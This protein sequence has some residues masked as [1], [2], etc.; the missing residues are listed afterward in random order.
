[1]AQFHVLRY[2]MRDHAITRTG[3]QASRVVA[4]RYKPDKQLQDESRNDN[5]NIAN[6]AN[7]SKGI[8][9]RRATLVHFDLAYLR[10]EQV[11]WKGQPLS[12]L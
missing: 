8:V 5:T 4:E 9:A 1:M 10:Q 7:H 6:R 12:C 11:Y 3:E 2:Q